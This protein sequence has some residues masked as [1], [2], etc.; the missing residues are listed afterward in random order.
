MELGTNASD[1]K[2]S[3]LTRRLSLTASDLWETVNS[4]RNK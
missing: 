1:E 2:D 3:E 4:G